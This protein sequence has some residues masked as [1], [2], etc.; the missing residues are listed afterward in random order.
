MP[1]V[2]AND[3]LVQFTY[4]PSYLQSKE[5]QRT[6]TSPKCYEDL[7]FSKYVIKSDIIL[8]G[9]SIEVLGNVGLVSE[10]VFIENQ[11]YDPERLLGQIKE[12]LSLEKLFLIPIEP[13]DILGHVDGL[14]RLV[15]PNQVVINDFNGV[16]G[17]EDFGRDLKTK[18][19]N[20]GF[21]IHEVPYSPQ[22]EINKDGL[23]PATGIYTNFLRIG[24]LLFMPT[25]NLAED[26]LA[27][28]K[29]SEIFTGCEVIPVDCRQVA[30]DGGSL[31]CIT[32][33]Y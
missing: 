19:I 32:W 14:V 18:L 28:T 24:R 6:I 22:D 20:M 3:A 4:N 25:Y 2:G 29:M 33:E 16:D 17:L 13:D 12:K 15:S 9:G 11:S 10:Q 31:H 30:V 27:Y 8:D 1:V 23:Y 5:L 21:V 7:S 26:N